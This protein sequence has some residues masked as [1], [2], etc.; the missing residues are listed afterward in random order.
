MRR[1]KVR[2]VIGSV[3]VSSTDRDP[4]ANAQQVGN[5]RT[6]LRSAWAEERNILVDCV[7]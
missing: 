2:P 1:L 7:Y 5:A 6:C 4:H 3:P